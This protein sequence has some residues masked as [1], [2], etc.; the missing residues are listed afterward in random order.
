[1]CGELAG[2]PA[3]SRARVTRLVVPVCASL[4]TS[5]QEPSARCCCLRKRTPS[6]MACSTSSRVTAASA[7]VVGIERPGPRGPGT[8][9]RAACDETWSRPPRELSAEG[10]HSQPQ[11]APDPSG[12][13]GGDAPAGADG[14][15]PRADRGAPWCPCRDDSLNPTEGGR[16]AAPPPP[17]D[18]AAEAPPRA[19]AV[20]SWTRSIRGVPDETESSREGSSPCRTSSPPCGS[21]TTNGARRSTS[22]KGSTGGRH[23]CHPPA[24]LAPAT[25]H[26]TSSDRKGIRHPRGPPRAVSM[27]SGSRGVVRGHQARWPGPRGPRSGDDPEGG[28]AGPAVRVLD[29]GGGG[30]GS[31]HGLW[32]GPCPS[33][34]S[35]G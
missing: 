31:A 3:V 4:S 20:I 13:P 12:R 30:D 6:R 8:Q 10:I 2:S 32:C 18:P 25:P 5:G 29:G 15:R 27:G 9:P 21:P 23:R 19:P 35:P 1:M 22:T 24:R 26:K 34:A 33:P 11:Y 17:R 14:P 28:R 16:R 7:G